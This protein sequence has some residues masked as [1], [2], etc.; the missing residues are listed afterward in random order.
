MKQNRNKCM[1][2]AG[3]CLHLKMICISVKLLQSK[4]TQSQKQTLS[5]CVLQNERTPMARNV[6]IK[7]DVIELNEKPIWQKL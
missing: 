2:N 7:L 4:D 6:W 1:R 5:H 3:K